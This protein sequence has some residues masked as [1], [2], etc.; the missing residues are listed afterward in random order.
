M[1]PDWHSNYQNCHHGWQATA[2][3]KWQKYIVA[4]GQ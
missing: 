4:Y 2:E 3:M 1:L